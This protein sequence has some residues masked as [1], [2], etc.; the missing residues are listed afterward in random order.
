MTFI[1]VIK[2]S[3]MVDADHALFIMSHD[4]SHVN[5]RAHEINASVTELLI[6]SLC[7]PSSGQIM[8][9]LEKLY[10]KERLFKFNI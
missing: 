3:F 7:L 9:Q 2:L 5:S 4:L 1:P 10:E 6:R 8:Q